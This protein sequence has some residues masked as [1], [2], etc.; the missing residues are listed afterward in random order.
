MLI[1]LQQRR[2][3]ES[4]WESAN[5]VLAAGEIAF[6]TDDQTFRIGDGVTA[7]SSLPY[8]QNS[9]D[10]E[11]AGLV[12]LSTANQYT[13][14]VVGVASTNLSSA[15]TASQSAS[16]QYTNQKI[17]ELIDSAPETL[18]TL[19]EIATA[20]QSNDGEIDSI[21]A[22]LG[23][24]SDIGHTHTIDELSDVSVATATDN[25]VLYY[26]AS[27]QS[28]KP[29]DLSGI[30]QLTITTTTQSGGG[31]LS[32]NSETGEF[33][34]APAVTGVTAGSYAMLTTTGPFAASTGSYHIY[35]DGSQ[36]LQVTVTTT[37]G[38]M[39]MISL[40]GD[41]SS[42]SA[43]S[44][45]LI[46]SV[47]G[48]ETVIYNWQWNNIFGKDFSWTFF[49]EHNL[50]AG[51]Q[52]TYLVR[53]Q[54]ATATSYIGQYSDVQMYVQEVA[55]ALGGQPTSPNISVEVSESGTTTGGLEYSNG[56][57]TYTPVLPAAAALSELTDVDLADLGD[58]D[59]LSYDA[60]SSTWLPGSAA[61]SMSQLTDVDLTNLSEGDLLWYTGTFGWQPYTPSYAPSLIS[62]NEQTSQYTLQLSDKD[63]MVEMNVSTTTDLNVPDN[64][65]VPFP[66]G[67]TIT[68]MQ[69]GV[70]QIN[71]LGTVGVTIN[72]TP[73]NTTRTQYSS[74]TLVKR[75]LNTWY[76]MGDLA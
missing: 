27:T 15:I 26:D 50:P 43:A 13:D 59:V 64:A 62:F 11:A 9:T 28:W 71:I 74:V 54:G 30:D 3:T 69:K 39:N 65:T 51:T 70:G 4:Q 66:I 47:D 52:I 75:D 19:N 61:S 46:R 34:F 42:S 12:L 8:F 55:G 1:R 29:K 21:T 49:D 33:V 45:R 23:T 5:P 37:V 10:I 16:E 63:A 18:N 22:I 25:Q 17:A 76:L 67:T 60:A 40:T 68:I 6:S 14:G 32:Y 38:Y 73:S 2:G 53:G 36:N 41:H 57:L 35:N 56:I 72:Y 48:V 44:A 20:L 58:G 24:K 31:S 7:W